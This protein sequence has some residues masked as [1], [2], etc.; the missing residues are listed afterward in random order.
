MHHVFNTD[1]IHY[2]TINGYFFFVK[3]FIIS[4]F[5][6]YKFDVFMCVVIQISN[7]VAQRLVP[8]FESFLRE[9]FDL[10]HIF[11]RGKVLM[12]PQ[13]ISQ[14]VLSLP[15]IL[16]SS[17]WSFGFRLLIQVKKLDNQS[18]QTG[19][20]WC[21]TKLLIVFCSEHNEYACIVF[22]FFC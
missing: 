21:R 16:S 12:C 14:V 8:Q 11:S 6:Q 3:L 22:K 9:L 5:L 7:F 17:G 10:S 4:R 2:T 15:D 18:E 1:C 13:Q 19:E 20:C